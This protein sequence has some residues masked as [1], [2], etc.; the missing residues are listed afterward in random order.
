MGKSTQ[1][2]LQGGLVVVHDDQGLA[3]SIMADVFIKGNRIERVAPNLK[4]EPGTE[5]IDCRNKIVAP[6]FVDTHRHMYSIALRG[7]HGDNLMEDY[8][9]QGKIA[10]AV[11]MWSREPDTC[12]F[13]LQAYSK[14]Q[15]LIR[16]RSTGVSWRGVWSVSTQALLPWLTTAT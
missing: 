13:L 15:H 16:P 2:L 3:K 7:R 12:S 14:L 4:A 1:I 11:P 10:V 8:L 6:G 5:V 9:A